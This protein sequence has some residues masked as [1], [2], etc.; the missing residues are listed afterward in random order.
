MPS[1]EPVS[2]L[3]QLQLELSNKQ[4]AELCS[5]DQTRRKTLSSSTVSAP[6][7]CATSDDLWHVAGPETPAPEQRVELMFPSALPDSRG[8][9]SYSSS[10]RQAKG[11]CRELHSHLEA[12]TWA[13]WPLPCCLGWRDSKDVTGVSP[14]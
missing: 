3:P 1:L 5:A 7:L 4:P 10:W 9:T 6:T 14:P 11:I 12:G 8:R 13:V 2:L